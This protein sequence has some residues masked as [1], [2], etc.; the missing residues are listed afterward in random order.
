MAHSPG[1]LNRCHT[2]HCSHA[3]LALMKVV[4]LAIQHASDYMQSARY[5]LGCSATDELEVPV[6]GPGREAGVGG[7]GADV[8]G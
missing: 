4:C 7:G 1:F 3:C 8:Q 6:Q 2:P 5:L